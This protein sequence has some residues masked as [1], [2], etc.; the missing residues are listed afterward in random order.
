M[1]GGVQTWETGYLKLLFGYSQIPG[2]DFDETSSP[3]ARATSLRIIL[4]LAAAS[5]LTLGQ[6]DFVAAYLNGVLDKPIYMRVSTGIQGVRR[7]ELRPA[8]E[9][10]LRIK[11]IRTHL[12]GIT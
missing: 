7:T 6:M 11:T 9:G 1:V 2:Q 4:A 5:D 8:E 12:V 3:V 10:P